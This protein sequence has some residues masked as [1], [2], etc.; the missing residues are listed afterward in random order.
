MLLTFRPELRVYYPANIERTCLFRVFVI[1]LLSYIK[2]AC[3]MIYE[4]QQ[5]GSYNHIYIE[6]CP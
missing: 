2:G 5:K 4:C 1:G 6:R 3:M